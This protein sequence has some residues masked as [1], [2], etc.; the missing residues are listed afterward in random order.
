MFVVLVIVFLFF[1]FN[2]NAK[3]AETYLGE[4]CWQVD[5]TSPYSDSLIYKF[6]VYMKDGGHIV[7]YGTEDGEATIH[8]NAEVIGGNIVMSIVSTGYDIADHWTEFI[9]AVLD[10][11]TLSGTFY[12]HSLESDPVLTSRFTGTMTLISCP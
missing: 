2:L 7:L 6:G 4:F 10:L 12:A 3:A 8:G 11:A 9:S 1:G 5:V